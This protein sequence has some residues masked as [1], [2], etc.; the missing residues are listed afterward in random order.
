MNEPENPE[1]E[2]MTAVV[3]GRVQGVGFRYYVQ[4]AAVLLK[5][6]GWVRNRWDGCVEV[7]AE[8]SHTQLL[9]LL[10]LLYQGPPSAEVE[11]VDADWQPASGEYS[12]FR[13]KG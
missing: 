3:S 12:S 1:L 9:Q 10:G 2:R 13:V 4:Q 11:D 7:V 6:V 8:G 5:L